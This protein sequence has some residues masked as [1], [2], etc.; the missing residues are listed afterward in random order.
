MVRLDSRAA[1][2]AAREGDP[3]ADWLQVETNSAQLQLKQPHDPSPERS[4]YPLV[5]S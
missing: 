5:S 2:N 1:P 3:T 4:Y